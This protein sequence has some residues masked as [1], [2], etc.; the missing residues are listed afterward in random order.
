MQRRQP[1]LSLAPSFAGCCKSLSG[2]SPG[3][4]KPLRRALER[5]VE[6][7]HVAIMLD[8]RIDP[9]QR[10]DFSVQGAGLE[11]LIAA[12]VEP[13]GGNVCQVGPVLYVGPLAT[14]QVLPTVV[15]KQYDKTRALSPQPQGEAVACDRLALAAAHHAAHAASTNWR[16]ITA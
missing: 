13:Y 11:R 3:R 4:E 7:Q 16:P 5:L 8:R 14:T 10:I 1:S 2:R 12:L 9:D 15:A 6:T